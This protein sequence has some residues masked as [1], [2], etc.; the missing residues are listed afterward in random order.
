MEDIGGM[1]QELQ[2]HLHKLRHMKSEET[3]NHILSTLWNTRKTGLPPP[4]KSNFQSLLK[5]SS[6]SQL[7]PVLACLRWLIRKFV[8]QNWS[9]DE[10]LE[11]L[12]ADLPLQLQTILLLTFQKNRDRWKQDISS[13]QV[14]THVPP[15][16]SSAPSSSMSIST[17]PRQD[18]DSLS[19]LICGDLGLSTPLVADVN[20][21]GLPACFQCDI[22]SSENLVLEEN[23]PFLKSMTWTMENGGASPADRV[24]IISL[25]LQDYS[26][27]PLG[28]KELK[29]QLTKDT[30]EAMLRSMT[31]ISERL[32]AVGTKSR[33]A[34][35]KQKK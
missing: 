13:Q 20:E 8:Y 10:L 32:S 24:A 18:H 6:H 34:N 15:S 2:L 9:D 29:F 26:K 17:W 7:D 28:E 35:K 11:L 31:Y 4:D 3:L 1:K 30:L 19:Q 33:P 5:L 27:S 16:F 12:P 25:K 22:T 21:S 14:R 23:L